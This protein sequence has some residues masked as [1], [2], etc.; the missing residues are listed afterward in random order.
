MPSTWYR[1]K[2]GDCT[3]LAKE[4]ATPGRR[5]DLELQAMLWLQIADNFDA[6]IKEAAD[7]VA[8]R[9]LRP[10]IPVG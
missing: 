9:L 8:V 5:T 10:P 2:S 7:G 1:W 4:A 6:Q 3:R